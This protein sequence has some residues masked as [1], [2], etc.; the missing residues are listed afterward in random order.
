MRVSPGNGWPWLAGAFFSA[1][2]QLAEA[3]PATLSEIKE[4]LTGIARHL[5]EAGVGQISEIFDG[6]YPHSPRGCIAQAW[7][8]SE[9]LRLAKIVMTHPA[10][11]SQRQSESRI[12]LK[13][14]WR[15]N[16]WGHLPHPQK[17]WVFADF[18]DFGP[19][20]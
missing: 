16:S 5:R 1:K 7:S 18:P 9:I 2:L 4:W 8:V 17:N 13:G 20:S 12:P 14:R 10:R 6:D 19:A 11:R 3:Y 15:A